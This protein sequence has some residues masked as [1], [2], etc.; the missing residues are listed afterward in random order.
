M[1]IKIGSQTKTNIYKTLSR[2]FGD[3]LKFNP[4]SQG[5]LVRKG[6]IIENIFFRLGAEKDD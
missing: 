5:K 1:K 4:T 3:Y 2:S 6:E